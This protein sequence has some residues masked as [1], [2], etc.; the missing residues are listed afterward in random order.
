MGKFAIQ[1]VRGG[2]Q[3]GLRAGNGQNVATSRVF[4]TMNDCLRAIEWVRKHADAPVSDRSAGDA[5]ERF[6]AERYQIYRCAD[7]RMGFC[8]LDGRGD[9]V[10]RSEGYTAKRSCRIGIASIGSNAPD[11]LV[12]GCP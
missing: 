11:A 1:R 7:G 9:A 4:L 5:P 10:L 8:L 3:F 2:Y 12:A 6:C